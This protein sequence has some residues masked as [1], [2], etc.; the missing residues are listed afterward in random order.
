MSLWLGLLGLN[1]ALALLYVLDRSTGEAS[2]L[3]QLPL[4]DAWIHLVYARRFGEGAPFTFSPDGGFSSG[5]TSFLWPLALTPF[6]LIGFRGLSLVWAAWLL[7][8]VL[9]AALAVETKRLAEPLVGRNAA[10]GAAGRAMLRAAEATPPHE[11]PIDDYPLVL[12]TG[13]TA[14][15]FHTRT[16]TARAPELNAA[17]P[18]APSRI[19]CESKP[20]GT[21]FN[22]P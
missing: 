9:H 8:T 11:P 22:T 16:K 7:G 6:W 17:P 20:A 3:W 2:A 1:L 5:A 10:I 4:D 12:A 13:R 14:Y 18:G 19:A 15:H 21:E